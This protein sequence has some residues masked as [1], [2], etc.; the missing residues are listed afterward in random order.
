MC[1]YICPGTCDSKDDDCYKKFDAV[2]KTDWKKFGR[3]WDKVV[4]DGF[5]MG[6]NFDDEKMLSFE[7]MMECTDS[8]IGKYNDQV[9]T[10]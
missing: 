2:K 3:T 4:S 1:T 10:P 9:K 6:K 5:S 8:V 7:S